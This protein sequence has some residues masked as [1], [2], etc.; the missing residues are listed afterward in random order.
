MRSQEIMETINLSQPSISRYLTQLTATG[1]LQERRENG[2]KV[3][4][5]NQDRSEKTLKAVHAFLLGRT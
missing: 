1:Y 5:L 2:A 4:I 3:Y